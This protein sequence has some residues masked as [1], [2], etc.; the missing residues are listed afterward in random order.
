MQHSVTFYWRCSW[1]TCVNLQILGK[2]QTG[3]LPYFRFSGQFFKKGN[4]HKSR[5][6]D[7]IDIKLGPVTKLDKRNRTPTNKRGKTKRLQSPPSLGLSGGVTTKG[8]LGCL[9]LN[10]NHQVN[11]KWLRETRSGMNVFWLHCATGFRREC[12]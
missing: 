7:D 4:C 1:L 8:C 12:P 10:P 2:N 3:V 6:I 11:W 5:T 9:T